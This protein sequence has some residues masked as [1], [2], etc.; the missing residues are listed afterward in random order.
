MIKIDSDNCDCNLVNSDDYII[1]RC[2]LLQ[3]SPNGRTRHTPRQG[4][5]VGPEMELRHSSK[6]VIRM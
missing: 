1:K 2:Q 6:N 5:S 3:I 4:C